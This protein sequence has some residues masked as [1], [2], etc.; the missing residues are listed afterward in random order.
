MSRLR[1]WLFLPG[2]CLLVGLAAGPGLATFFAAPV[3]SQRLSAQAPATTDACATAR[4]LRLTNGRI[5]TMD[6]RSTTATEMTIQNGRITAMGA[7]RQRL[8]PCTRTIDLR[9]RTA[10]PGLID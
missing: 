2:R 8:S 3:D 5:V 4:D 9:G 6:T 10:V 7:A 1:V